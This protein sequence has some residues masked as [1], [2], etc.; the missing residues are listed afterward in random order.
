MK[1]ITI[2]ISDGKRT[3]LIANGEEISGIDSLSFNV[4]A[5]RSA[6]MNVHFADISRPNKKV[7][8]ELIDLAA[9]QLG[10]ELQTE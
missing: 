7:P 4:V 10:Y 5:P 1:Q 8:Q 3:T 9:K 6:E 2:I